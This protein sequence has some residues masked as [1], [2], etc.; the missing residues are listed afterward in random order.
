MKP[1]KSHEIKAGIFVFVGVILL[2]GAII[3]LGGDRLIFARMHE[4]KVHLPQAQGLARGSIVT[5]VGVQVGNVRSVAFVSGTTDVEVSINVEDGVY[6]RITQGSKVTVKTQGALG[7]KYIYI[8]PGPPDAPLLA[9]GSVIDNDK[10]PDFIDLLASKGAEFGEIVNV[11]KE[12]KILFENINR[13]GKSAKLISN[14]VES[15]DQMSKTMIEARETFRILRQDTLPPLASVMKKI[16]SGQG[17]LGAL[18]NDSS[19]HSRI[20]GFFGEAPRNRFLKP[21]IR[22]SIETNEKKKYGN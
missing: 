8:E 6:K 15:T 7:D 11:I 18:V 4:Y 5:L 2:A 12:V 16:D 1:A 13:D 3:M 20:S 21:L 14:L 17:T 19:L 9:E 10:T 22:E